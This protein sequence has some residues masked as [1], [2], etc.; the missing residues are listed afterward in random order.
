MAKKTTIAPGLFKKTAPTAPASMQAAA[1][2]EAFD[3]NDRRRKPEEAKVK[4]MSVSL[5]VAEYDEIGAIGDGA[6]ATRMAVM[7]AAIRHTLALYRAG[8]VKAKTG[9]KAGRITISFE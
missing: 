5:T 3:P 4:P 6:G 8:K 2:D 1:T 7:N 9:T